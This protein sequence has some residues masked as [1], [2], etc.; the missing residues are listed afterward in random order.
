MV[1]LAFIPAGAA[2][3]PDLHGHTRPS[4]AISRGSSRFL[5]RA[6]EALFRAGRERVAAGRL[7]EG[8]SGVRREQSPRLRARHV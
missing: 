3:V 7:G 8:L 6:A 5:P 1:R 4:L 2:R